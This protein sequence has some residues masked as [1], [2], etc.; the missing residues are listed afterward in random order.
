[1]ATSK[2]KQYYS[3]TK[4]GIIRGNLIH[5]VAGALFAS[6]ISG[7]QWSPIIGVLIGTSLVIAA[8]C[9]ANNYLDRGIDAKMK[10][11][12]NRPS[13]TGDIPFWNAMIFAKILLIIGFTVLYAFTN[14]IVVTIGFVAYILYVFAYGW[15]K[16]HTVHSTLV[17]A[18][19]G[20][21]PAMA[22]YVAV[23]GEL[24]IAAWLIF[25]LITAWQMPHFYAISLFRRGD[26]KAA[27][28]PVLGAV[29]SFEVVKQYILFYIVVY[30]CVITALIATSSIS[31][32][33]GLLLLSGAAYWLYV[34]ITASGDHD[35][36]ARSIF[37]ASL[38]LTL[39]L[40][41]AAVLN[42]FL[43]QV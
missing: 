23:S 15:A 36:W 29:R 34:Y 4:P 18:L 21:L 7:F 5:V 9:V 19:P 43:V 25:L 10:R 24:S 35:K 37:G 17:G 16:R 41:A 22:G 20:A 33:P 13:V 27:G 6:S 11:T 28:I 14:L 38:V 2:A 30:T 1:M 8:A 42:M 12:K 39:I 32:A 26:Y 3:L 31:A 40:P